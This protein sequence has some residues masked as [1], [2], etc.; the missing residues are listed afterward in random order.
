MSDRDLGD[1][2]AYLVQVAPV[3]AEYPPIR[4]GLVLPIAAA[5]GIFMPVASSVDHDAKHL[6]HPLPAPTEAYGEYLF[7]GCAGCHSA[8]V[9]APLLGK[10]SQK[11]FMRIIRT[12]VSSNGKRIDK[13]MPISTYAEMS[14]TELAALW[15]YL[16]TQ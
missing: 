12:G 13:S 8:G 10:W 2:I 15:L 9:T 7:T 16:R 4:Y 3:D 6:A 5:F 1:L 11:D 14:D